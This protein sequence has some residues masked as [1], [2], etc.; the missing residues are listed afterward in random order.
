VIGKT[1]D[2]KGL[3]VCHSPSGCSYIY[4]PD[5]KW[6]QCGERPHDLIAPWKEPRKWP[7]AIEVVRIEYADGAQRTYVAHN[8]GGAWGGKAIARR[9]IEVELTEGE[10]V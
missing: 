8:Q 9:I 4:Y 2:G 7:E 1:P 5:G 3:V 6:S 10:G